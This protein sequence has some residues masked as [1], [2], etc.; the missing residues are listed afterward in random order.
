MLIPS[1]IA[2]FANAV[3]NSWGVQ[4]IAAFAVV[5]VEAVAAAVGGG[6]GGRGGVAATEAGTTKSPAFAP[7]AVTLATSITS[8][9][10]SCMVFR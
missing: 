6:G 7:V 4:D 8:A 3:L 2:A 9:T 5:G 10:T 1:A